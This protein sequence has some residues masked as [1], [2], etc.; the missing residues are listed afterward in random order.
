MSVKPDAGFSGFLNEAAE[1]AP[2]RETLGLIRTLL[3]GP[4]SDAAQLSATLQ[5]GLRE[6]GFFYESHLAR[7]FAGEYPLEELLKEPQGRHSKLMHPGADSTS[8]GSRIEEHPSAGMK[9]SSLEAMEAAFRK[10]GG[11]R[12]NEEA[13][14]QRNAPVVREQLESLRS[15]QILFRGDLFAGKPLEWSIRE[16]E[17]RR[18][19]SAGQERGW[20]TALRVD[21]PRLGGITA[22]LKLDGNRISVDISAGDVASAGT[23]EA[24]REKLAD[25]LRAAGLEPGEIGVRHDAP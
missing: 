18:N 14:D 2:L 22:H 4:P 5:R 10:A 12:D 16:R 25:Q 15:G 24:G 19:S 3:T 11:I 7:W 13:I 20:D 21:L 6:S 23:L 9:N 8:S 1:N 17:A